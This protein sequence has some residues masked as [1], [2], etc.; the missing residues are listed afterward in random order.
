MKFK[1]LGKHEKKIKIST[2]ERIERNSQYD[3]V[4]Q[5][6]LTRRHCLLLILSS[7]LKKSFN[8]S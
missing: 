8:E 4:S 3:R 7:N 2:R 6:V 1:N 5:N